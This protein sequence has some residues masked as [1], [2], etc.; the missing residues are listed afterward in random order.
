MAVSTSSRWLR[1]LMAV[2]PGPE[3]ILATTDPPSLW[4]FLN[5]FTL[6]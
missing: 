2:S 3:L 6:A 1:T 5:S 4:L